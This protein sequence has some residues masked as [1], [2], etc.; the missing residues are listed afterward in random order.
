MWK[1]APPESFGKAKDLRLKMTE[2]EKLLRDKLNKE[3]FRKYKFRSQ[4]PLQL[5]ILDFYSHSLRLAIEVDGEYHNSDEQKKLDLERTETLEFQGLQVIRFDNNEI[6]GNIE[7]A[8]LR[9][10]KFIEKMDVK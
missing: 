10:Q 3:P 9:L 4:H 1:G 5:Y 6:I 2:A 7:N 8:L